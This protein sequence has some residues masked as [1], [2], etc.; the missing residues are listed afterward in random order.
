MSNELAKHALVI[1]NPSFVPSIAPSRTVSPSMKISGVSN[2]ALTTSSTPTKNRSLS[3]S[4]HSTVKISN[5]P[6]AKTSITPSSSLSQSKSAVPSL[7]YRSTPLPITSPPFNV[8]PSSSYPSFKSSV[9]SQY[10]RSTP[11]PPPTLSSA[12]NLPTRKIPSRLPTFSTSKKP[13][14][15][16][17]SKVPSLLPT[18]SQLPSATPTLGNDIQYHMG[19]TIITGTVNLYNIYY[20]NFVL[21]NYLQQTRRLIDY[22]S[23]NVGNSSWYKTLSKYYQVN[24]VDGSKTYASTSVVLKKSINVFPG[25]KRITI[26]DSDIVNTILS[27]FNSASKPLPVDTNGIYVVIF[28]GDFNYDGWLRSWCGFHSSFALSDGR[29]INFV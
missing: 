26:T 8:F 2:P 7:S 23:S 6:T 25:A 5:K 24:N 3:P 12:S 10:R 4:S 22:F 27:Q 20:G 9:P 19:K 14:S 1:S 13:S 16:R 28:R 18:T 11:S 17:P 15:F 21:P 29:M